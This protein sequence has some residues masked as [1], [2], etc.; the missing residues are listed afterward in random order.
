MSSRCHKWSVRSALHLLPAILAACGSG[1]AP[2][3]PADPARRVEWPA[4]GGTA[5]GLRYSLLDDIDRHNVR[6]VRPAWRENAGYLVT[7]GPNVRTSACLSLP[8]IRR[9]ICPRPASAAAD[10]RM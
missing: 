3:P 6:L 8:V 10:A 7:R 1:A 9:V 5:A 2:A 4:V